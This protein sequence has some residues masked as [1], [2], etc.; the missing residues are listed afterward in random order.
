MMNSFNIC[1]LRVHS[2]FLSPEMEGGNGNNNNNNN[3]N[4]GNYNYQNNNNNGIDMYRQYWIGPHCSEKDGKSI[5]MKVFYDAG[6]T[7]VAPTGTY[8][9][10]HYSAALPFETESI[11]TLNDCISCL[12]AD[13]NQNNNNNNNNN[14]QNQQVEANELCQ[15]SYEMAAKC[16][17]GLSQYVSQYY[18]PDESGCDFINNILPRLDQATRKVSSASKVGSAKGG[19][20]ATAFAVLFAISSLVLGAYAFFLYR[21]IHR[22]KVNLSQAELGIA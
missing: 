5:Y 7:S 12:K 9:A 14:N 8:E 15:Q 21:K 22:A 1:R 19:A 16:E 10:F 18:Y 20:A 17:S 2:L 13:E 11:V 6:C 4:N 3:Q